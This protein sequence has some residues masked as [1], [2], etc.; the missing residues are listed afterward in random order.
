MSTTPFYQ[1]SERPSQFVIMQIDLADFLEL[2]RLKI[3]LVTMYKT[4]FSTSFAVDRLHL[5]QLYDNVYCT[6]GHNFRLYNEITPHSKL[7][8]KL[9]SWPHSKCLELITVLCFRL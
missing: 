3:D 7:L 4:A 2:R 8:L 9:I 1:T 5:V 6:S